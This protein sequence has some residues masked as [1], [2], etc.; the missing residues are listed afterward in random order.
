MKLVRTLTANPGLMHLVGVL[1]GILLLLIFFL[2]N[3]QILSQPGV[4]VVPPESPFALGPADRPEIVSITGHP[5]PAI[6]FRQQ[7]VSLPEFHRLLP[8]PKTPGRTAVI[9]ADRNTPYALV[10]EVSNLCLQRGYS[11]ALAGAEKSR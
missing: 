7:R 1:D 5:V 10:A 2:L 4:T 8:Q 3:S 6:Y 9:Q 11:V